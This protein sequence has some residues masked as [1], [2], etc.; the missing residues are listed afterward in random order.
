MSIKDDVSGLKQLGSQGT[1]YKYD[2]PNPGILETFPNRFE[3]EYV[4]TLD[5]QEF[6]SL[7]PKTGQPDFAHVNITYVP[8][9][10]CVETKSLKLYFFAF[11]NHGSFMES[12]TNTI[13]DHL[14]SVLNP[15]ALKVECVF[16]PRGGI[17]LRVTADYFGD[18]ELSEQT[19]EML[20]GDV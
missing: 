9:A 16:A 11:R 17:T 14:V 12:I 7:C 8:S 15:R 13:R 19:V 3:N 4:V 2:E 1:D 10:K 6:T 5:F 20:S 18:G